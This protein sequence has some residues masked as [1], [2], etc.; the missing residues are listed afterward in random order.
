MPLGF[1]R[2]KHHLFYENRPHLISV[3]MVNPPHQKQFQANLAASKTFIIFNNC[4]KSICNSANNVGRSVTNHYI[5][6]ILSNIKHLLQSHQSYW[7]STAVVC[8]YHTVRWCWL[9]LCSHTWF[10]LGTAPFQVRHRNNK[11]PGMSRWHD[12]IKIKILQLN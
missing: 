8:M 11:L 5:N 4:Y 10:Y 9:L 3:C 6:V 1:K 2:C 12:N 7:P